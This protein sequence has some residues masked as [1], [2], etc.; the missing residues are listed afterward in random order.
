MKAFKR[1]TAFITVLAVSVTFSRAAIPSPTD[2]FYVNDFAGVLSGNTERMI[3]S[4][5]VALERETKAQIV[6]ATVSSL[7]GRDLNDYSIDMARSYEI[8]DEDEDNGILILLAPNERQV[9]IE[10]GY[11][12]EGAINDAKAGRILD[13]AGVP[14]FR[15]D[16]WDE[17]ISQVYQSVLAEVYAEYGLEV[18]SDV[19]PVYV[20]SSNDNEWVETLVGFIFFIIVMFAIFGRGRIVFFPFFCGSGGGHYRGGGFYGGGFGG[21]RSGGGGFSGGGG[22]FGGGGSGRSF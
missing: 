5:S 1:L 6:V 9:K 11:G 8:G 2:D 16:E 21:G 20:D 19:D 14:Y 4:H 12:L 10:V 15:E 7:D 17:G 18:P 13:N 22:S 3:M